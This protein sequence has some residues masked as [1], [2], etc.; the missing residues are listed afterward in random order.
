MN[1]EDLKKELIEKI[2]KFQQIIYMYNQYPEYVN[3]KYSYMQAQ[4]E[5]EKYTEKYCKLL[6]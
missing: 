4:N 2:K 6:K 1:D 5:L 3:N